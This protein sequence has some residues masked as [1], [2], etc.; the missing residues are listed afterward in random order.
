MLARGTAFGSNR[1]VRSTRGGAKRIASF[2]L[3]RGS[4]NP[5]RERQRAVRAGLGGAAG[6]RHHGIHFTL[7]LRGF[8]GLGET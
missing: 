3:Y 2:R 5:N 8:S 4:R 7:S 1:E 6:T